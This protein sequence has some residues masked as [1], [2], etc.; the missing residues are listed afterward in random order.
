MA[1]AIL[2]FLFG[3]L[4]GWIIRYAEL[5]KF[6]TISRQSDATDNRVIKTILLAIGLGAILLA[7]LTGAGLAGFHIKTLYRRRLDNRMVDFQQRNGYSR[8]LSRNFGRIGR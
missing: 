6:D 2:I 7:L 1:Q 3:A 4:F 5:N 8:L